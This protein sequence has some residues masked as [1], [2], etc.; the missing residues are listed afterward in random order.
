MAK[1]MVETDNGEILSDNED[2]DDH[3]KKKKISKNK[4]ND[5]KKEIA[6]RKHELKLKKEYE[7]C[8]A[9]DKF[10][11]DEDRL[12]YENSSQIMVKAIEFV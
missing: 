6:R 9:G 12:L 7:N 4:E 8:L 2:E 1:I 11:N 10:S 3:K 5:R